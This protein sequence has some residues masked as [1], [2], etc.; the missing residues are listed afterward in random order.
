MAAAVAMCCRGPSK[1][2]VAPLTQPTAAHGLGVGAREP[3][4]GGGLGP[5]TPGCVGWRHATTRSASCFGRGCNTS[6]HGA[7]WRR[8]HEG[9]GGEQARRENRTTTVSG[10]VASD[11]LTRRGSAFPPARWP[12]AHPGRSQN[13]PWRAG[14]AWPA[15]SGTRRPVRRWSGHTHAGCRPALA[16]RYSPGPPRAQPAAGPARPA[17][18]G[19]PLPCC[20]RRRLDVGQQLRRVRSRVSV[21]WTL[22]PTTPTRAR[23]GSALQGRRVN[24]SAPP[25]AASL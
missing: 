24:R 13:Q 23:C 14:L 1:T 3:R 25:G 20:R 6:S 21:R 15:T 9:A 7:S 10:L 4:V 12:S 2:D 5:G 16:R 19:P 11:S 8:V 18:Y 17:P 22:D